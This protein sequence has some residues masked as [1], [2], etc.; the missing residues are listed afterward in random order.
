[1]SDPM[2]TAAMTCTAQ[3]QSTE[4]TPAMRPSVLASIKGGMRGVIDGKIKMHSHIRQS[5]LET[6]ASAGMRMRTSSSRA[7]QM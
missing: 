5:K 1:M 2:L 6:V 4:A 3:P 7:L